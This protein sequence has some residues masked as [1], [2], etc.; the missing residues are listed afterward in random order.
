MEEVPALFISKYMGKTFVDKTG[1][2]G[3]ISRVSLSM[4]KEDAHVV[5]WAGDTPTVYDFSETVEVID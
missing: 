4:T 1:E 2:I 5:V 3:K